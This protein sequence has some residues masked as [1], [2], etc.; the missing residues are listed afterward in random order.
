MISVIVVTYNRKALLMECLESILRQK[1]GERPEVIVIDNGSSD[2]TEALL[3][4]AFGDKIIFIRTASR[5]SLWDVKN[6]GI[7]ESRGDIIAL[8]DDDCTVSKQWLNQI[9]KSLIHSD[10]VGGPTYA[11]PGTRFPWWWR[12]SLNWLIGINPKPDHRFLPLG[13][14][15]AFRKNILSKLEKNKFKISGPLLPYAEDRIRV[16]GLLKTGLLL[17]INKDMIVYHRVPKQRLKLAYLIK[18]SYR[19]G[20]ASAALEKEIKTIVFNIIALAVNPA[21]LILSI[22]L[23]YF[24]RTIV[25]LS[26]IINLLK[27][28][29]LNNRLK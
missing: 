19:E 26:F 7:K 23:N 28:L 15:I 11:M 10:F 14:N 2:G 6:L 13:S 24:F 5:R 1:P 3:N 8:T 16:T 25:N 29:I 27:S 4:N 21:R 9:R 22:D 17:G 18:R 20:V 12:D